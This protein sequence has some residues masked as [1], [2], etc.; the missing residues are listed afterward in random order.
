MSQSTVSA[1]TPPSNSENC[2]LHGKYHVCHCI[3]SWVTNVSA[4]KML[5]DKEGTRDTI[6]MVISLKTMIAAQVLLHLFSNTL[7][8][9]C[10]SE[11][12]IIQCSSVVEKVF[13]ALETWMAWNALVGRLLM[14][15]LLHPS[16]FHSLL[17]EPL[18]KADLIN[19][20][21]CAILIRYSVFWQDCQYGIDNYVFE[22]ASQKWNYNILQFHI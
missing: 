11:S 5:S 6:F 1:R 4:I 9:L 16:F 22:R 10:N 3:P 17:S 15:E 18:Q 7:K 2:V 13:N 8:E 12:L 21:F 20:G 19:T 14:L